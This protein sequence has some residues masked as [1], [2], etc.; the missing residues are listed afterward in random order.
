MSARHV[1]DGRGQLDPVFLVQAARAALDDRVPPFATSGRQDLN[2]RPLDPQNGGVSVTARQTRST[3]F[4]N[5]PACAGS[6]VACRACGPQLVPHVRPL[7]NDDSYVPTVATRR[8]RRRSLRSRHCT[9][10]TASANRVP[11][12]SGGA[13]LHVDLRRGRHS[14]AVRARAVRE[15]GGRTRRTSGP[16]SGLRRSSQLILTTPPAASTARL[17]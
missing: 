13:E 8:T 10:D 5:G 15:R 7:V 4:L 9:R 1:T 11:S 12:D 17:P 3:A 6:L 16:R 14:H 2:L